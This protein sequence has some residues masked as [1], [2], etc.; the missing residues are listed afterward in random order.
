MRPADVEHGVGQRLGAHALRAEEHQAESRQREMQR[1]GHGEQQQDRGV[2]DRPE[3][4]AVE[5]WGDR[6]HQ[7]QRQHDPDRHRQGRSRREPDRR[8]RQ[9]RQDEI[10]Q[11]RARQPMECAVPRESGRLDRR[12]QDREHRHQADR[13]RSA[14]CFQRGE[15]ER[16]EGG[17]IAERHEDHAR[18]GEDQHQAEAD[19]DIDGPA[20]DAV[21]RQDRRDLAASSA[22]GSYFHWPLTSRTITSARSSTP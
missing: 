22:Q 21:H 2:G 8:G 10:E 20:G 16:R 4:D 12:R 18:H 15:S 7:R 3:H 17:D 5:Q 6:Q 13:P 9:Q 14:S 11:Q 1:H 19:Q